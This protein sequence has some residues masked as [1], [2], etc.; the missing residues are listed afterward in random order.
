MKKL[1]VA[2]LFFFAPFGFASAQALTDQFTQDSQVQNN[3][4]ELKY[5][6]SYRSRDA[7]TNG[8][9]ST[10]QDFLSS[11]GYL[12]GEPTGFFGLQTVAAVK[13]FQLSIG[14]GNVGTP[15]YGG[16]GPLT[17]A[18]IKAIS[19]SGSM[20]T[21]TS[22]NTL[23]TGTLNSTAGLPSG[24]SSAR[25]FSVTTGKRCIPSETIS[26]N[27]YTNF[28]AGCTSNS[29]YSSMSGKAC[30]GSTPSPRITSVEYFASV[31][32][33]GNPEKFAV[34]GINLIP[35]SRLQ[36]TDTFDLS[37]SGYL[38]YTY[39]SD[40]NQI[41]F[42]GDKYTGNI[43]SIY[44]VKIID[45]QGRS[46]NEVIVDTRVIHYPA[47]CT[48]NYGYSSF[49]G[50]ACDGSGSTNPAYPAGCTSNTGWSST[51]GNSCSTTTRPAAQASFRQSSYTTTV[52]NPMTIAWDSSNADRC[53]LSALVDGLLADSNSKDSGSYTVNAATPENRDYTL[54]CQQLVPG[55]YSMYSGD[56]AVS[57]TVRVVVNAP[58]PAI[59]DV[60]SKGGSSG[61]L[62]AGTTGYINGTGL[63]GSLTI[64]VG[65]RIVYSNSYSDILATFTVPPFPM[66]PA[67][68]VD[69]IVTNTLTNSTSNAYKVT[70]KSLTPS[71]ASTFSYLQQYQSGNNGAMGA[72]FNY[73]VQN[74][75]PGLVLDV[76]LTVNCN[77]TYIAPSKRDCS[78]YIF[79]LSGKAAENYNNVM[80]NPFVKG[81]SLNRF[82][83]ADGGININGFVD[84]SYVVPSGYISPIPDNIDYKF[85]LR[86]VNQGGI[87]IWSKTE[88]A[89]FKG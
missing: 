8:D 36:Y 10:L 27:N 53:Q 70:V 79:N 57:R 29:G 1:L 61:E 86:D 24:C 21:A 19:C 54:Y 13:K 65:G 75:R 46:S 89:Q 33:S 77:D 4:V 42:G 3:C 12:S 72:W 85:I 71:V 43:A 11:N 28:P 18:K 63:K 38:T 82:T 47:G 40:T 52:G 68:G 81:G 32:D 25:G 22:V 39:S 5:N 9:V 7:Q 17:R 2:T 50:K 14:I 74:Y 67:V 55:S 60:A 49:D 26:S 44:K 78:K 51:T 83:G 30:D 48:S 59:T 16:V 34:L 69:V 35:G 20:S 87:E 56:G 37:R 80:A 58:A 31:P 62:F 76:E 88:R 15:G 64:N 84:P 45:P 23:T 73:Q 41:V 6:M 66:Y